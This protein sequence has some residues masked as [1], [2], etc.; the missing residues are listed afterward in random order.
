MAW[1]AVSVALTAQVASAVSAYPSYT[2]VLT[3]HSLGGA[4]AA[5][6]GTALRNAGYSLE[7]VSAF[8]IGIFYSDGVRVDTDA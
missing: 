7:L 3:G 6:G 5:L 4:L 2:L 8:P 1:K